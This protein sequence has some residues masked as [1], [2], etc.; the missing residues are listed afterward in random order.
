VRIYPPRAVTKLQ[1][2]ATRPTTNVRRPRSASSARTIVPSRN[3]E[4]RCRQKRSA[5]GM[6]AHF[7][8]LNF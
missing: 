5:I 8:V 2:V 1:R 4:R 3:R 7:E 6:L